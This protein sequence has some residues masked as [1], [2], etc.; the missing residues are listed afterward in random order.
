[1]I[2]CN[3]FENVFLKHVVLGLD[4]KTDES[5]KL[6]GAK[7]IFNPIDEDKIYHKSNG[8]PV[9]FFPSNLNVSLDMKNLIKLNSLL[10]ETLSSYLYNIRSK[11]FQKDLNEILFTKPEED[12][13]IKVRVSRFFFREEDN[14]RYK[15]SIAIIKKAVYEGE[16]DKEIVNINFSKR[17]VVILSS[18]IRTIT[19]SYLRS[20]GLTTQINYVNK[21]T[22]ELV[23]SKLGSIAKVDSSMLIDSVWLHGQELLNI[24]YTVDQLIFK[25]YIE[26]NLNNLNSFYRQVRFVNENEIVYLEIRKLNNEHVEE[27]IIVNGEEC[28]I[29]IPM[30]AYNISAFYL[31]LDINILRHSEFEQNLTNEEI[32][33]STKTY[34]GEKIKFHISMKESLMGIGIKPKNKNPEESKISL[35]FKVKE[36]QFQEENDVSDVLENFIKKYNKA[37]E[38]ELVP[39]LTECQIDLKDQWH[40]LIAALGMA[41]TKEYVTEEKKWNLVKFFVINQ[42]NTGKYKYE[43]TIFADDGNKAPAVLI[44]DKY[45]QKKDEQ[46]QFISRYRQP[47]FEKYIY[48]LLYI[49]L[50]ASEDIENISLLDDLNSK[51]MLSFQYKS[52]K[53]VSEVKKSKEIEYGIKKENQEVKLGNFSKEGNYS[54]LNSQDISLLN[55]SAL[56]RL[57]RGKWLPFVGDK[58]AIGQDGYLTDMYGELNMEDEKKGSIWATKIFFGTSF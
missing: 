13:Y 30:S 27:P 32:L 17:D 53:K 43:F 20:S 34:L 29:R 21:N 19:A 35:V 57:T 8:Q 3:N 36:G 22:G 37:G 2:V 16:D 54:I 11:V 48:Q 56:N 5:G 1:M 45:K 9:E 39:V 47:L 25:L 24:M 18:L 4:S 7:L 10:I 46:D 12:K 23:E 31:Y 49:I 33:G 38:K 51:D 50:T 52:F 44:I 55:L 14:G 28:V 41:Y 26:K 15:I 42:D 58:V 40:K 6:I